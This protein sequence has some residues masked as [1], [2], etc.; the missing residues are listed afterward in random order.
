MDWLTIRILSEYGVAGPA[1]R[2]P[3][4]QCLRTGQNG[5]VATHAIFT[6]EHEALRASVRRFVD[7]ELRPF[8]DEWEEAGFFPDEVFRRSGELGFLGLHYPE[9]W[10]GSGGDLAS[11]LVF[12]EELGHCGC[13]AIPMAVAVQTHMC[14]PAL[15]EFGSDFLRERYLRPAISGEK[16]GAIALTEP[17]AGSDVAGIATRAALDGDSWVLNGSKMFITNGTRAHFLTLAAQTEPGTRH[18]GVTLFVVDTDLAGISISRKLDKLGMRSSDTAEIRFEDVRVPAANLI[19]DAPG[20]GF[21]QLSWQLQYERLSGAAQ[22]LGQA[23]AVLARTIEYARQ[24]QAFGRAIA[25]NQVIAHMLADAATELAAARALTYDTIWR[26]Q[27]GEFPVAEISMAKKYAAQVQ[28]RLAD[29]CLQIFGG[30]GYLNEEPVSRA[31]RDARLQRIGAGTDEIMNEV[32][33]KRLGI[34]S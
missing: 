27:Q 7:T 23:D 25:D 24:R 4:V 22:S 2:P 26:V 6:D 30:Y 13:G 14:T 18:R 21:S 20:Q 29:T 10:G 11:S 8:V 3:P 32:I 9:T 16:I 1:D 33:A 19:G 12:I 17:D 34:R 15:A 5:A 31:W 28:N